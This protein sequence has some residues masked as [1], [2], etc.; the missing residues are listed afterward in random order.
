MIKY[1]MPVA[2]ERANANC[3]WL[4]SSVAR[5]VVSLYAWLLRIIA[6]MIAAAM[7]TIIIT[8]ALVT[9]RSLFLYDSFFAVIPG[10]ENPLIVLI[11]ELCFMCF[12]E[13]LL[14]RVILLSY[15]M[16]FMF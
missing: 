6:T 10:T 8:C 4:N 11:C 14:N 7:A 3:S 9:G 13:R 2:A 15:A 12:S 1:S 16:V 5:F